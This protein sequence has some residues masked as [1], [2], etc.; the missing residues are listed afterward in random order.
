VKQ[1]DKDNRAPK[2]LNETRSIPK[3]KRKRDEIDDIFGF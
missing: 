1:N 2:R 3:A